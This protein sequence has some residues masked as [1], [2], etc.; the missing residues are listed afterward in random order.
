MTF[1]NDERLYEYRIVCI[2]FFNYFVK[3]TLK[4]FSVEPPF[5][6]PY[7]ILDCFAKSSAEL[8]GILSF[9]TVRKAAKLAVYDDTMINVK[10]HQAHSAMRPDIE[11]K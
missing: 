2:F 8:I 10:N 7:F 9:S 11:L 5:E 1:V 4:N 3:H 6:I